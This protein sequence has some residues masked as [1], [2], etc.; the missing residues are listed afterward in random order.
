[1]AEAGSH[2]RALARFRSR[3]E[4]TAIS[5]APRYVCQREQIRIALYFRRHSRHGIDQAA[6]GGPL[7]AQSAANFYSF[8]GHLELDSV[9]E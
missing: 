6:M 1:M 2:Q 5:P 3:R 4:L 7:Q 9:Q 8:S